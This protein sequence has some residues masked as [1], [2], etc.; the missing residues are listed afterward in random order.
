VHELSVCQALLT[1]V[2]E[3]A[4]TQ[5]AAAVEQITI[6]VGPLCGT[7]PTLLLNAFSAMRSGVTSSAKLRIEH[8]AVTVL[9]LECEAR[10]QTRSNRLV[11][12]TCGGWRTRVFAGNELRLLKVEMRMPEPAAVAAET[13]SEERFDYV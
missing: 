5:R 3:I 7:E 10:T 9:C 2:G 11:C 13:A 12:G 1:Q 6:E 4:R 8:S